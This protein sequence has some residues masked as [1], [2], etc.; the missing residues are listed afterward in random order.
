MLQQY[1]KNIFYI[2]IYFRNHNEFNLGKE[3]F[4]AKNH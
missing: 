4:S 3:A 1:N 2:N